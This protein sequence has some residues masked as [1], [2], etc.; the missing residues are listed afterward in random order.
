MYS[1]RPNC[2]QGR[3]FVLFLI[4]S[5]GWDS[6]S[7]IFDHVDVGIAGVHQHREMF[8]VR[9]VMTPDGGT[10]WLAPE[11]GGLTGKVDVELPRFGG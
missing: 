2:V 3:T 7:K 9:R 4:A 10:A 5:L 1:S 11:E 8:A 6:S